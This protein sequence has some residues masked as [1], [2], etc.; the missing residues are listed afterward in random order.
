MTCTGTGIAQAGQ[1]A[2]I[3]SVSGTSPNGQTVSDSDPSHYFGAAPAIAIE[4]ATNGEDADTPTGPV[5]TV[6]STV[7]WT[8]VV[9][10][11]GNVPLSNVAVSDDQG[12]SVACPSTTLAV[13]A[14][15]TCT[16]SGIAQAGQYANIGSV[17]GIAPNGQTVSDSDPSH[18]FGQALA[19]SALGDFVWID[20]D[21]NG[22]QDG[23]DVGLD[24]VV[25]NLLDGNGQQLATQTTANGGKYLFDNLT[26]GTYEVEF[27][28]PNGYNFTAP[29]QGGNDAVDS[30]ANLVTGRTGPIVLGTGQTDLRWDAGVFVGDKDAICLPT[31][32]ME[33]DAEGTMLV[34]G[35]I[36]DNE[37]AAYGVTVTT[38][39]PVNHPAMIF[40]SA[41]PTGG[42]LDLGTPNQDFGGPGVGTGGKAGT[43]GANSQA[44]GKVLIIS[45]DANSANPDDN[46][47]GGMLIFSFAQAVR[48]DSLGILDIEEAGGSVQAFDASGALIA[49]VPLQTYGD[50]SFQRVAL[51]A[52]G[53]STLKITFTGSGAVTDLA[54]CLD[55]LAPAIDIRKQEEGPDTRAFSAG[56]DVPFQIVVT[57]T[58]DVAL[59]NVQV[60]DPLAPQCD[61]TIGSLAIGASQ[62]YSC[63]VTLSAGTSSTTT[64]LFKDTFSRFSYNNNDG[65]DA[66]TGPWTEY[67]VAGAGPT[68]GNVLVGSNYKL[69]LDDN[70]DTGTQP[71]AAR[72]ADLSGMD[73]ATLS[74]DYETHSGVDTNDAVVVEISS[75]G[76]A[77][78]TVLETF[79]GFSGAKYGS[80]SYDVSAYISSQTTIRFRVSQNY[81]GSYETFKVDNV[82]LAGEGS[83]TSGGASGFTN[84]VCVVGT[85]PSGTVDDCDTSTVTVTSGTTPTCSDCQT[86]ITAM[87]LKITAGASNRPADERVRVRENGLGGQVLYDS[88][89]DGDSNP[90]VPTGGS[91]SFDIAHPG[92][93]IVVTVQGTNH[94]SEYVKAT[95]GTDCGTEIGDTSGN[96]YITF[97]VTA[98]DTDG[99]TP[100]C[101]LASGGQHSGTAFWAKLKSAH[102]GKC[103][104]I[105]GVST[106]DGANAQQ[107][108]CYSGGMNQKVKFE[109]VDGK[110]DV[111]TLKFAHSGKCLDVYGN[112]MSN[113]DTFIQWS[114]HG[115]TNQ[116]FKLVDRG[117]G[118]YSLTAQSSG[119]C[120]DVEGVSS[121]D[122]ADVHQWSYVGGQNQLWYI[123]EEPDARTALFVVGSTALNASDASAKSRLEGLGFTVAVKD[124][125]SVNTVDGNDKDLIMISSTVN[126]GYVGTKFRNSAVP[127]V[128]WEPYLYDDLGMTG[129]SAGYDFGV[130]GSQYKL[131][132]SGGHSMCAGLS[133]TQQVLNAYENVTWGKP[134][135]SAVDIA[136]VYGTSTKKA[137]FGYDTGAYMMGMSAPARRVGMFLYNDS[138]DNM[139]G[140]GQALFDAA[141]NWATGR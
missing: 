45:E 63:T 37:W 54:Y 33:F 116:Q 30:D 131:S 24:G 106:Q 36:I 136:T 135:G 76:G 97:K 50:N 80:R 96:S 118:K 100:I 28:L 41:N 47:G 60:S 77:S 94:P 138:A 107:W 34:A 43:I 109:P 69:W 42:D 110:T 20:A 74:F 65:P 140:N 10:N 91:F 112:G 108:S 32:D 64:K 23:G 66:W 130:T 56:S 55:Q 39:D 72:T 21:R 53:V 40:D 7:T 27:V 103:L 98:A 141:V 113:G 5:V 18:Y 61:A 119:K 88:F 121:N 79:T 75:D 58:G 13:G 114:C 35:Q 14:S 137:I 70:P 84:E 122:G 101:E 8:Y 132:V 46:A 19:N 89:N 62:S 99:G 3:G 26:A 82:K 93:S 117:Y 128:T 2:N 57:N 86:A 4:K 73:T 25:V 129:G 17:T 105:A 139:G 123:E 125:S 31:F 95:F 78:Y 90:T 104:D 92:A 44:Q 15:M 83:S 52:M 120:V 67:D 16:G 59:S 133:G 71:S 22:L 12:V 134:A 48:L 115:G 6:G 127:V 85:A 126:S 29:N 51:N 11:I 81:G 111:Y 38:S 9:S 124:D 102:S 49:S 68:S 1:Y 87:T